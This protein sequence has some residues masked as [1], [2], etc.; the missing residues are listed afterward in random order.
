VAEQLVEVVD[1]AE[2]LDLGVHSMAAAVVEVAAEP[3]EELGEARLDQGTSLAVLGP[4]G[5]SGEAG[6]HG[7]LAGGGELALGGE[8]CLWASLVTETNSGRSARASK[9]AVEAYPL[10]A[11]QSWM[12]PKSPAAWW[13]YWV[14]FT[15][16]TRAVVSEGLS[17]T[18]MAS[19]SWRRA[20]AI[21][22]LYPCR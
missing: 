18:S 1:R 21:C 10:S 20:D 9:A 12:S 8:P 22:R 6:G 7:L 5:W 19:R 16:G 15:I 14:F 13:L 11:S 3:L 2:D 17:C 4:T